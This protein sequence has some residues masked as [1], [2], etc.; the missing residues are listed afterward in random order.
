MTNQNTPL[1]TSTLGEDIKARVSKLAVQI[2]QMELESKIPYISNE[3]LS[4]LSTKSTIISEEL[5]FLYGLLEKIEKITSTISMAQERLKGSVDRFLMKSPLM[6]E[7][8]T[9]PKEANITNQP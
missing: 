3:K 2:K 6:R 1:R 8:E 9:T 7:P 4:V 5:E